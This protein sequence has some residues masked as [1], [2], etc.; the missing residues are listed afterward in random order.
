M[1]LRFACDINEDIP[2]TDRLFPISGKR[3]C[4]GESL[5]RMELFLFLTSL[6]Q[7]FRFRM[8]DERN[9][10]SLSGTLGVV[11]APQ[12]FNMIISKR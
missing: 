9:P 6:V 5:A 11:N 3:V 2:T 10:P 4:I 1:P 12:N 7:R 8:E